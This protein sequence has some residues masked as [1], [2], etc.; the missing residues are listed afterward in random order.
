MLTVEVLLTHI[1]A[2]STM[3]ATMAQSA[4]TQPKITILKRQ[5]EDAAVSKNK[6]LKKTARGK[7]LQCT[8]VVD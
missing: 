6:F 4:P 8:S 1:I 3:A 2:A 7:V 5:R